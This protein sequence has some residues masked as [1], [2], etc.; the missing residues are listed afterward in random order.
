MK[1][2]VYHMFILTAIIIAGARGQEISK[3]SKPLDP[4]NMDLSVKPCDDF[5]QYANG[6]WIKNAAI[7]PAFSQWGSFTELDEHN[8]DVLHGILEDAS[9]DKSAPQGSNRHKIGDFYSTGMDSATIESL[10]WKPI[11]GDLKQID[12]ISDIAGVQTEIARLHMFGRGALFNFGSGQDAKNSSEVIGQL[13]QGGL[14][15]P[16]RDYY[17]AND[18]K[19]K[20]LRDAYISYMV[21]MFKLIG[22]DDAKAAAAAQ[23]IM[24]VETRLAKAARTRVERRDVEKNYHRM[25]QKELAALAPSFEWN[26][27]FVGV[28]WTNPGDVNVGQPE[29]FKTVDSMMNDVSLDSWKQ[30]LCWRV[31][32]ASAPYLSSAFVNENFK[33]A[34][35]ALGG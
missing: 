8:T 16:D 28:G 32:N 1:H 14:G 33:F 11:A 9:K 2:F 22:Y 13:G 12:G 18:Q 5:N 4:K 6:T 29:F 31:L 24:T 27:F 26:R 17:L 3:Q 35:T 23:S 19:S 30:Y 20:K 15:M 10:G 7:P 25:T 34:G 21:A